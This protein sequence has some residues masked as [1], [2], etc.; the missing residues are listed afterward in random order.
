M[1]A[2]TMVSDDSYGVVGTINLDYRSLYL[3]LECAAWLYNDSAISTMKKDFLDTL[4]LCN[5]VTLDSIGKLSWL[6]S[7][8]LGVLRAF[9]PLI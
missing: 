6:K 4:T 9:A 8:C 5:E 2:K 7:L 1:H 3:H